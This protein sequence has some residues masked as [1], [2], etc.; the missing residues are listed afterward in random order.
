MCPSKWQNLSVALLAQL[1]RN[2]GDFS[3]EWPYMIRRLVS[4]N[5][6]PETFQSTVRAKS[7]TNA[8]RRSWFSSLLQFL[9][10]FCII[11]HSCK[12]ISSWCF[13]FIITIKQHRT[14][15]FR[16]QPPDDVLT[17]ANSIAKFNYIWHFSLGNDSLI[18]C[19]F[20]NVQLLQGWSL[21]LVHKL[22][23]CIDRY[24][25]VSVC[26]DVGSLQIQA[27][28]SCGSWLCQHETW[29]WCRHVGRAEHRPCAMRRARVVKLYQRNKW[30][31]HCGW[32]KKICLSAEIAM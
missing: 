16:V 4:G 9:E 19:L 24:V 32:V 5:Y 29:H 14:R 27:I 23:T 31:S 28:W 17:R 12:G 30:S 20:S 11:L 8:C 1:I 18:L 22:E 25:M 6:I 2:C 13:V 15:C 21:L 26:V 7:A 10:S 3:L